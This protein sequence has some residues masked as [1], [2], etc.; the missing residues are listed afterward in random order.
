MTEA[1]WGLLADAVRAIG[2]QARRSAKGLAIE[3]RAGLAAI[4]RT[5][6]APPGAALPIRTV[7]RA[8]CTLPAARLPGLA[9]PGAAATIAPM[10]NR[11]AGGASALPDGTGLRFVARATL[12]AGDEAFDPIHRTLLAYAA[13]WGAATAV[14]A[15]E[16][17]ARGQ[18]PVGEGTSAWTPDE[19]QQARGALPPHLAATLDPA[20]PHAITGAIALPGGQARIE[21]RA[22]MTHPQHGPGLF[23]LLALP[24]R[25]ATDEAVAQACA[26]LNTLEA[27][28]LDG[29]PHYGAWCPQ[30]DG[31]AAYVFFLPNGV[32]LAIIA[33][34]YGWM[35]VRAPLMA[36]ALTSPAGV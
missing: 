10:L 6:K 3:G 20:T 17:Q 19:F 32:K 25:F 5:A 21:V 33:A 18:A 11:N 2:G 27:E 26:V 31:R 7:L 36:A 24:V 29:P 15:A 30:A 22:D 28:P 16:R 9:Q 4:I 35:A 14:G 8:E 12:Y 13:V 1:E 23:A 34:L